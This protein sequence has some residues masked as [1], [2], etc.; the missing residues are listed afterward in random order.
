MRLRSLFLFALS[1]VICAQQPGSTRIGKIEFYGSHGIDTAAIRKN[2]LFHEGDQM[3]AFDQPGLQ[4]FA[5][6]IK[7]AVEKVTGGRP[8]TNVNPNC[9]DERGDWIIY[10]G[11]PGPTG[12]AIHYNAS[13]TGNQMLP[14]AITNVDRQLLDANMQAV[15][16]GSS[17]ED[18]SKGYAL[19]VDPALRA[20]QLELRRLALA[21]EKQV[22]EVLEKSAKADQRATAARAV[23]YL[24][25]SQRQLEALLHASHDADPD[26]RNNAVRAL[27]VM[28]AAGRKVPPMPFVELLR[29]GVWTDRNK[30]LFVL[31]PLT[32]SRDRELLEL[33]RTKAF[34]ELIEMAW[35]R[36]PGQNYAPRVILG[37][38]ANIE[39]SQ[40]QKMISAG[41]V[42]KIIAAAQAGRPLK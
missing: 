26:T 21:S 1:S 18:E 36:N 7:Q 37:R 33:L 4:A 19:S 3:P 12:E 8:P 25:P 14:V 23:G 42:D 27:G 30:G 34:D 38:I 11:L 20:R 2:L 29:S 16:K 41:Q 6:G 5:D 22:Y 24:D 9:C 32:A 13:P 10:I 31:A 35:W 17:G 40:L 15:Q 28:A 39:E